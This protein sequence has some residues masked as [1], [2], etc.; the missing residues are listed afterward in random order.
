[1]ALFG[2]S[3]TPVAQQLHETAHAHMEA[4]G[5]G[6]RR[7]K[8]VDEARDVADYSDVVRVGIDDTARKRNQ[9]YISIMADLDGQRALA[10]PGRHARQGQG[11]L[12]QALRRA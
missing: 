1:M 6:R 10:C 3:V 12:R 11:R 9:S 7:G 5:Q 2:M 4:A 8:A